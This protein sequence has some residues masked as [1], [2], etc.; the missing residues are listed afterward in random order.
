MNKEKEGIKA[1]R[2]VERN[3]EKVL[4]YTDEIS[5]YFC[6]D[7]YWTDVPNVKLEKEPEEFY[8]LRDKHTGNVLHA[9]HSKDN[10]NIPPNHEVFKVRAVL[11]DA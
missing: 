9:A 3:G 11:E 5:T 6:R 10:L 1:L 4:Q 7:A 2:F 8:I